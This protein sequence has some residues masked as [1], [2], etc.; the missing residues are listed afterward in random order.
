M[1][2]AVLG[3]TGIRTALVVC[4]VAVIHKAPCPILVVRPASVSAGQVLASLDF[5]AMNVRSVTM[6]TVME[7]RS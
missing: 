1:I 3:I 2:G 4:N 7:S 5:V 6:D